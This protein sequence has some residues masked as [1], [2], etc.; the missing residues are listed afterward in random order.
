MFFCSIFNFYI[1]TVHTG[2]TI[3]CCD[4][5]GSNL[6]PR[7]VHPFCAPISVPDD[8]VFYSNYSVNCMPYVRSIA[9]MRSDCSLGSLEQVI[10]CLIIS[11]QSL[12]VPNN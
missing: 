4:S 11:I 2:N 1:F 6:S 12:T 8:D 10:I 5:D 9:A 7:Y 3:E